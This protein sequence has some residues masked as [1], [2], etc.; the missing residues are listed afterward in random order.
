MASAGSREGCLKKVSKKRGI[1][2]EFSFISRYLCTP[3]LRNAA[4][5]N[6]LKG[7]YGEVAQVVRA[8]DS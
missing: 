5:G 6:V 8:L 2:F 3:V 4:T 7:K 1:H